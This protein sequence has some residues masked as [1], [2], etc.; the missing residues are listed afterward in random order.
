M[1]VNK[2]VYVTGY[3][4]LYTKVSLYLQSKPHILSIYLVDAQNSELRTNTLYL[5][6]MYDLVTDV[7]RDDSCVAEGHAVKK[8]TWQLAGRGHDL[9]APV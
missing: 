4:V 3:G 5:T 7:C 9:P 1:S 6:K 2:E 8:W